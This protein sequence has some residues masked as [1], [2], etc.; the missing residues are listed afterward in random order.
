MG[1][2]AFWYTDRGEKQ[3]GF[4]FDGKFHSTMYACH[5]NLKYEAL[6]G[7]YMTVKEDGGKGRVVCPMVNEVNNHDDAFKKYTSDEA[8][9]RS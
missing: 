2:R 5:I 4:E 9:W 1:C 6:D 8:V 7:K 3:V